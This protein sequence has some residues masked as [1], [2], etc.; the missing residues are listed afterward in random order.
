MKTIRVQYTVKQEFAEQNQKNINAVMD[1]LRALGRDDVKYTAYR[2]DD[3]KTFMHLV[4]YNSEEAEQYPPSLESFK[5]FQKELK[6]N[7]E[8][9][10]EAKNL[11]VVDSSFKLF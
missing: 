2:Y 4:Q 11:D 8:V 1:E 9:P 6:E 3:G 5:H 10:P 7:I